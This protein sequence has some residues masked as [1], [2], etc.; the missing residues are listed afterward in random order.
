MVAMVTPNVSA[1][2][3]A[4]EADLG[5]GF[6]SSFTGEETQAHT[7][8]FLLLMSHTQPTAWMVGEPREV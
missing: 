1:A 8:D 2:S 3:C 5:S 4:G 7:G 6:L